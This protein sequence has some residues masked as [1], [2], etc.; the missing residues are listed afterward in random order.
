MFET[1]GF[2]I[3]I[4]SN[5]RSRRGKVN[6]LRAQPSG[7]GSGLFLARTAEIAVDECRR[8]ADPRQGVGDRLTKVTQDRVFVVGNTI[9]VR[10]NLPLK[11]KDVAFGK[12]QA[13]V[14]VSAPI[15][16][17]KFEHRT[18][19][20]ANQVVGEIQARALGRDA[21]NERYEPALSL[22]ICR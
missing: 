3:L 12:E 17:P 20:I 11:Y 16:K 15:A 8:R 13:K 1:T 10:G 19:N 21:V 18:G 7:K 4:G 5:D 14:V 22:G 6:E 2:K 9:G